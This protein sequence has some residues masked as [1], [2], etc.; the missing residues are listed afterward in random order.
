M[1]KFCI[2]AMLFASLSASVSAE[3]RIDDPWVR[4]TVAQQ[5]ATGAFMTITSSSP[6]RLVEAGS[7]AAGVV[8]IHEMKME[9]QVMRM[10][11]IDAIELPAGQA[12]RLEPGGYHVMM[13]EVAG[14]LQEGAR[15]PL[16]LTVET[17]AGERETL[18]VEAVVRG[19][20]HRHGAPAGG[21]HGH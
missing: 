11:R 14:P 6:A 17:A 10:R 16:T 5:R 7:P 13:M 18:Q 4:A 19:L 9:N 3:V 2:A 8:E 12:V 15:V 21:H 1:K 20:A